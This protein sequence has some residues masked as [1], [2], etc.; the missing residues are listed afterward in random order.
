MFLFIEFL[1]TVI[2]LTVWYLGTYIQEYHYLQ[3]HGLKTN[4]PRK[5]G[6]IVVTNYLKHIYLLI[7]RYFEVE[8][9]N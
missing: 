6:T 1:N 9:Q 2:H 3:M 7:R 8:P 5:K 4:C